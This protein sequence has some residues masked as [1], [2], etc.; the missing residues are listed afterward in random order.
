MRLLP[1]IA[2]LFSAA[3]VSAMLLAVAACGGDPTPTPTAPAPTPTPTRLV[4][5][6]T[7]TTAPPAPRTRGQVEGVVFY[8]GD[9]SEATFTVR[10][11]LTTVPLPFDAVIRTEGLSG[12]VRLDG[13]ASEITIDLH[14]MTSDQTNRDRY[15]RSVMF[16]SDRYATISIGDLTPLPAGF[17]EGEEVTA[18]VE[19]TLTIKGIETPLTFNVEARD[20]GDVVF[21]VGRTTWT[22]AQL[23]LPVPSARIVVSLAD[24][25]HTE[26]LLSLSADGG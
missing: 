23:S 21:V 19:G 7:P 2:C 13:A 17:T 12:E 9:G 1:R 8:V 6:D 3:V 10:E 20:D 18:Q 4:P 25:V 22:W 15:I 14:S 5:A 11:E 24:E 16:P 26:V